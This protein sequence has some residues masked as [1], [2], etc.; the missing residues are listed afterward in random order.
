MSISDLLFCYGPA[1]GLMVAAASLLFI[2]FGGEI[3]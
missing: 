1:A 3:W 2:A